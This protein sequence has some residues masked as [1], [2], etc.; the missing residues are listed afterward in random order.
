MQLIRGLHNLSKSERG[1][2]LTIGNFDGIHRGHQAILK[3][4]LECAEV[5]DLPSAVMFFEPHP[6]ELFRPDDAPARMSRFRDKITYL[7]EFGIDQ[8]ILVKFSRQF[9]QMSAEHFLKEVLITQLGVKHLIVGDDFHFGHKRQGNFDYLASH[10]DELG[11]DLERT[12]TLMEE[13]ERISSTAVRSALKNNDLAKAEKLLGRP[14]IISGKVVHGDKRGRTI[15][16][17]TANVLLQRKISPLHGVYAVEV[18]YQSE[19]GLLTIYGVANIGY[20]PTVGGQRLQLEVHLFK[21]DQDIYSEH[22]TVKFVTFIRAEMKFA[23]FEQLTQQIK[24]D[25]QQAK[26]IFGIQ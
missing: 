22:I 4:L 17:P 3:R 10:C 6:E 8:L 14:Y 11:F 18:S 13:G 9:S 12:S 26:D 25:S 5:C 19:T 24:K 15:G 7:K 16:F 1:C 2:V 23:D 21:W 20:R